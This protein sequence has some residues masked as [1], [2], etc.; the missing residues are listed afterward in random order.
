MQKLHYRCTADGYRFIQICSTVCY[1]SF[2]SFVSLLGFHWWKPC[3]FWWAQQ[4]KEPKD[5]IILQDWNDFAAWWKSKQI[6]HNVASFCPT[7]ETFCILFWY[8]SS[9]CLFIAVT[10]R[11]LLHRLMPSGLDH[12][13]WDRQCPPP[14]SSLATHKPSCSSI[15]PSI[16]T[17]I[18][19]SEYPPI[20]SGPLSQLRM[21][22][23]HYQH[24]FVRAVN[25]S[26]PQWKWPDKRL[27]KPPWVHLSSIF[28]SY[29][30]FF[31]F[32]FF[33]YDCQCVHEIRSE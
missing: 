18:Q 21:W 22:C 16:H 5:Q 25:L 7:G 15:K 14:L 6:N 20:F 9:V 12:S 29:S 4:F 32:I 30:F 33:L 19:S 28:Y 23:G 24:V 10:V 11:S 13:S 2:F 17:P 27:W 26:Q 31:F 8:L 1:K 3:L